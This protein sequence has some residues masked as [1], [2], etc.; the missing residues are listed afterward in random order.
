MEITQEQFDNL[1]NQ[2]TELTH[3]VKILESNGINQ[4][5]PYTGI[6]RYDTLMVDTLTAGLPI[7]TTSS[8]VGHFQSQIYITKI[9]S[10]SSLCTLI[11]GVQKKV[12]LS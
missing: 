2:I 6:K 10:T 11:N 3:K 1:E 12:N 7:S 5:R 9:G 8:T 4:V